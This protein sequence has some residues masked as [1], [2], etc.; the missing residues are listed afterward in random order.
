[1]NESTENTEHYFVVA[2]SPNVGWYVDTAAT[3]ARFPDGTVWDDA[4]EEWVRCAPTDYVAK[5]DKYLNDTL[6]VALHNLNHT[7][8]GGK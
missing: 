5:W 8:K 1:M 3:D 4:T 7:N 2:Y 6:N